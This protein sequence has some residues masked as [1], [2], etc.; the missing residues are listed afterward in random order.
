MQ[1]LPRSTL[2]GFWAERPALPSVLQ[3]LEFKICKMR[4]SAQ[5]LVCGE[6][7][8]SGASRR[9]SSLV[10]GRTLLVKVFSV[11]HSVL[12]VDAY[13]PSGLQDTV[14]VRGILI[15][16]GYAEPAEE[17]YESK[18]RAACGW[19]TC[20]RA[21][22]GGVGSETQGALACSQDLGVQSRTAVC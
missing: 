17:P 11:V 1:T 2:S 21:P 18:V 5:C 13:L 6:R 10:S 7:W 9:F 14:S 4:P 12:H 16:Q 3:A 15:G 20:V 22:V 19:S 8:S